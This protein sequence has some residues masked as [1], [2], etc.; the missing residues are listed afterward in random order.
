MVWEECFRPPRLVL[1]AFHCTRL[2]R[3]EMIFGHRFYIPGSVA[4]RE[5]DAGKSI[6][7]YLTMGEGPY[8][9]QTTRVEGSGNPGLTSLVVD[10]HRHQILANVWEARLLKSDEGC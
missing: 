10:T 4:M 2:A 8:T 6:H 7:S 1:R 3:V 5:A 9:M